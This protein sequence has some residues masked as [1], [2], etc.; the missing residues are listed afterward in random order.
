LK[1]AMQSVSPWGHQAR[2]L[3]FDAWRFSL[4]QSPNGCLNAKFASTR[5][6]HDEC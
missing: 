6:G 2:T 3:A 1:P 5:M 4:I